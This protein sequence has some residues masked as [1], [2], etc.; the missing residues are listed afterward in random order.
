ME[1]DTLSGMV[2]DVPWADTL[3]AY[4]EAHFVLYAR[5]LDAQAAN[6]TPEEMAELIL[7]IDPVREPDRVQ[8]AVSNH[9]RRA[10][11]MTE[12]GYRH[13]LGH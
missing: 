8:K 5:L 1:K 12:K 2:D 9:L 4:D 7:G 6:A 13:L 11:W 10:Q 3:T